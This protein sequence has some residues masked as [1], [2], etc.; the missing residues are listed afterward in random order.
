[1]ERLVTKYIKSKLG[2]QFL[3]DDRK[4]QYK[5]VVDLLDDHGNPL[6]SFNDL[7]FKELL[8]DS[9]IEFPNPVCNE[10]KLFCF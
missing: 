1:M 5:A 7:V 6:A 4:D 3:Y 2:I 8:K 10:L 9:I